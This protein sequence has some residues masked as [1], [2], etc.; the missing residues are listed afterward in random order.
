MQG[1]SGSQ[2]AV[3]PVGQPGTGAGSAAPGEGARA[4][5]GANAL[6]AYSNYS[7]T[8]RGLRDRPRSRAMLC[9]CTANNHL[10]GTSVHSELIIIV[11]SALFLSKTFNLVNCIRFTQ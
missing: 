4:G 5:V 1:A 7:L 8:L 2:R 6:L 11:S 10:T 9:R 3:A